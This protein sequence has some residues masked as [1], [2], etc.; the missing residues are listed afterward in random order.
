VC[1]QPAAGTQKARAEGVSGQPQP[2]QRLCL[3]PTP[4]LCAR[5]WQIAPLTLCLQPPTLTSCTQPYSIQFP[6]LSL[7]CDSL[8][9]IC[10]AIPFPQEG[11]PTH[12][13][14]AVVVNRLLAQQAQHSTA[15]PH[16]PLLSTSLPRKIRNNPLTV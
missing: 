8:P 9:A 2:S 6:L 4:L 5:P 10:P 3:T 7:S 15:S 1:A 16:Q 14:V 13:L 12:C 11:R